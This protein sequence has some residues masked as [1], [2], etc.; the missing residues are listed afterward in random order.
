MSG[1][2]SFKFGLAGKRP[3]MSGAT[4]SGGAVHGIHRPRGRPPGSGKV[5][6]LMREQMER[7]AAAGQPVPSEAEL[8]S[9]ITNLTMQK[10]LEKFQN[11]TSKV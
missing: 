7:A 11:T 2:D 8:T 9:M 3:A 5:R 6:Q 10:K 4:S 1:E